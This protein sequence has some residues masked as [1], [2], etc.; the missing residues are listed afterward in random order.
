MVFGHGFQFLSSCFDAVLLFFRWLVFLIAFVKLEAQRTP[1][2]S[3]CLCP[4]AAVP[5]LLLLGSI[6]LF[7]LPGFDSKCLGNL[8]FVDVGPLEGRHLEVSGVLSKLQS[9]L[10]YFF[11]S[12]GFLFSSNALFPPQMAPLLFS[13]QAQLLG[14]VS[15]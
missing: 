4:A 12:L 8:L 11:V 13:P 15:G 14:V 6:I 9:L 10:F 2:T 5:N 1:P 7:L 3:K